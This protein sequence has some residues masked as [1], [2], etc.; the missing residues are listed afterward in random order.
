MI[1]TAFFAVV[2]KIAVLSLFI[3]LLLET[4][5]GLIDQWE[6]LIIITAVCSMILGTLGALVQSNIKR[7]LAYSAIGHMGYVLIAIAV[8]S[9]DG[10]QSLLLYMIVYI[11]M[12]IN[13]FTS[14]L[15]LYKKNNNLRIMSIKELS[16]LSYQNPLLAITISIT[17][18]SM[19]GIPPCAGF[20]SKLY[21][22]LAAINTKMNLL[23]ILGVLASVIGA[24][25]YIRI[26]KIMYFEIPQETNNY[27][28]IDFLKSFILVIS[29]L[30]ILLFSINPS[31]LLLLTHQITLNF[32]L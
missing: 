18:L 30:F 6:P 26:I 23:A 28:P 9:I 27:K 16:G 3:E 15:S 4:F 31:Y 1:V 25:Y 22:F 21:V 8:T 14:F 2:P 32:I 13:I 5:F 11:I 12:S 20:I 24:A 10:I 19:A 7:F 29:L 17:L